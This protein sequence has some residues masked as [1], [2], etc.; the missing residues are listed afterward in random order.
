MKKVSNGVQPNIL[1]QMGAIIP[2]SAMNKMVIRGMNIILLMS[3]G[4]LAAEVVIVYLH[5]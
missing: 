1:T 4:V 3:R 2:V 5:K